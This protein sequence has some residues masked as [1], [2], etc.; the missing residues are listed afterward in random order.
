MAHNNNLTGLINRNNLEHLLDAEFHNA[1]GNTNFIVMM[2]DKNKS[3]SI[4]NNERHGFN[5]VLLHLVAQKLTEN[6]RESDVA[7]R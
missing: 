1:S 3:K 5:D 7:S 4:N 6:I 2:A